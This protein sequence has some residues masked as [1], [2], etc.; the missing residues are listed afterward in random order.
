MGVG[1]GKWPNLAR[2]WASEGVSREARPRILKNFGKKCCFLSF[3]LEKLNFTTFGPPYKI[4][5]KIPY[6]P[7]WKKI[8]PTPMS[9]GLE[10][11]YYFTHE[12]RA[13]TVRGP[14]MLLV[15]LRLTVMILGAERWVEN[16]SLVLSQQS[17][18]RL[19]W[20]YL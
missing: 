5:G 14:R 17:L 10:L 2:S 6:W 7:P 9:Q 20:G 12:K 13:Q 16:L 8:L 18:P 3:E 4:F 19:W 1:R 15:S 11:E